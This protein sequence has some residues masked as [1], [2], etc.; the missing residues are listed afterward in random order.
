MKPTDLLILIS[1]CVLSALLALAGAY[2]FLAP[3]A[4]PENTASELLV[5]PRI[6]DLRLRTFASSAPTDFIT[7]ASKVT[8]AVVF[9]RCF[10]QRVSAFETNVEVTTTGS[11]VII[12]GDGLIATNNHVISGAKRIRVLLE[13]KREFDAEV[14]G[15]D[16]ST[17][18]AL[19]RVRPNGTLPSLSFGNSDSLQVGEWVLAVGN[20][21]SLNSTV[22]AGIVSA[23]GRSIDVLESND[24]IESFIQTDAAV[25]PG[26][27]GGALVNTNGELIGINTAIL[28]NSGRHEG[29]AFAIPGNLASRVLGDLERF[30]EVKRAR[31]GVYIQAVNDAQAKSLGLKSATGVLITNLTPNGAALR[32]G[33][34][35]GDVMTALNGV[36][37]SSAPE[38]Q[39]QLSRYRPGRKIRISY[40]RNGRKRSTTAKLRDK[41]NNAK[42]LVSHQE[43]DLLHQ[44]GFEVRAL[45]AEEEKV[46][47]EGGVNVLSIFRD[48][49]IEATNMN[50]GFII[51]AINDEPVSSVADFMRLIGREGELLFKG[52]YLGYEGD[53]FYQVE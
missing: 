21:F 22:T 46:I 15:V 37:I 4:A 30:G 44:L 42:A 20:P 51:T 38:M 7:A 25:N 3:A 27:S 9:I 28:T 2:T 16:E 17:D 24:R 36:E 32:A 40:I 49:P 39:E 23:K 13:D 50:V 14:I 19:L 1:C 33:L 12:G 31:L 43:E 26:N 48:S 53:Y 47:P 8:S 18:L 35:V 34:E 10:G 52:R 41:E 45:T 6:E 5:N 29:F 11:G